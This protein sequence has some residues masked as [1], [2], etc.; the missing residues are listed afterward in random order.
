MKRLLIAAVVLAGL[1]GAIWWSEKQEAAKKDQPDPKAPPKVL[2]L[3]EESLERLE[4][5]HPGQPT[6]VLVKDA[7]GVWSI[8]APVMLPADSQPV[9]AI[10]ASVTNLSS[11]RVVDENLTDPAAYG[12]EPPKLALKLTMKDGKTH[13]LRVGEDTPDRSGTYAAVDGDPRLY[14]IAAYHKTNFDKHAPQL[15]D[16]RLL[17]FDTDQL[18][19]VE[20]NVSGKPPLEFSRAGQSQWQILRPRLLRA[21]GLEVDELVRQLHEAEMDVA[22]MDP[23]GNDPE[24]AKGF[25]SGKPLATAK[26]TTPSGVLTLEVRQSAGNYFVRSSMVPGAFRALP[27]LGTAVNKSLDDFLNKKLFDFGFDD[28]VKLTLKDGDEER[29]FEKSDGKWLRNGRVMDSVGVQNVIDKLRELAAS[30]VDD[31][32]MPAKTQL[33][34]TVVSK[35]GERTERALVAQSGN[36]YLARRENEPAIYRIES[37]KIAELRE[38]ARNVQ[39]AAGDGKSDNKKQ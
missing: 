12:L 34:L 20:L 3:S 39:E 13:R 25:A 23:L 29:T 6:V 22:S 17:K 4:I 27:V 10:T 37:H 26:L 14:V 7:G 8:T 19:R 30:R 31:T 5:E 2:A 24:A 18:S 32:V 28:P 15:R 16:K 33:E 1:G 21:D 35:N 11:D 38:A 9:T 36:D